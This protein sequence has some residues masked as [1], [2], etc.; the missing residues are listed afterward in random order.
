MRERKAD[1]GT[2]NA[3]ATTYR[4]SRIGIAANATTPV[5]N[6]AISAALAETGTPTIGGTTTA[7]PVTALVTGTATGL[8]AHSTGPPAHPAADLVARPTALAVTP[9]AGLVAQTRPVHGASIGGDNMAPGP[10]D[11]T[12]WAAAIDVACRLAEITPWDTTMYSLRVLILGA[13]NLRVPILGT[14][15][16]RRPVRRTCKMIPWL[17]MKRSTTKCQL[18]TNT[19][20]TITGR[21]ALRPISTG[22]FEVL[23]QLF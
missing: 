15:N 3:S 9:V 19:A 21:T 14:S 22:I 23:L 17:L 11:L 1:C 10:H 13:H 5:E 6:F 7:R 16:I 2:S 8:V 4:I 12:P 20:V 18:T